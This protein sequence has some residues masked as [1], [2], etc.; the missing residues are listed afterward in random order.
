VEMSKSR[1]RIRMG[2]DGWFMNSK[3]SLERRCICT[4]TTYLH[5][6]LPLI[7]CGLRIFDLD[8]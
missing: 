6:F 1:G 4:G 8:F 2:L 7:T 3:M 5:D